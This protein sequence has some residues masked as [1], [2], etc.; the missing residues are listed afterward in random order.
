M[1][2][3]IKLKTKITKDQIQKLKDVDNKTPEELYE[4]LY[5]NFINNLGIDYID[6]KMDIYY[7]D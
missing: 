7:N 4:Y 3:E 2:S 1:I 6:L 5:N